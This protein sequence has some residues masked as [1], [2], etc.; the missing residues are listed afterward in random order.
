MHRLA[1]DRLLALLGDGCPAGEVVAAIE[2]DVSLLAGV[3]RLANRRQFDRGTVDSVPAALKAVRPESL[4]ALARAATT[5]DVFAFTESPAGIPQAVRQHASAVQGAA[6]G[7]AATIAFPGLDRIA[8][9]AGLHDI[10]RMVLVEAFGERACGR[11][12]V[13]MTPMA[14]LRAERERLGTDH[15]EVSAELLKF[16]G[17]PERVVGAVARHHDPAA[18]EEAVIVGL[19]DTLVHF[20]EGGPIDIETAV[21]QGAALG[22]D[23]DTL[24]RLAFDLPTG[25]V[26]RGASFEA[27]PLSDR[28]LTVLKH[29]SEGKVYKQIALEMNLTPSTVRSHLHRIY[30][31]IGAADRTQAV[32]LAKERGWLE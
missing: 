23:R 6:H 13:G 1:R 17:L 32:L 31:R 20:R 10:G 14:A 7:I 19:A 24:A 27:N 2:G 30:R 18:H 22:I 5:Y 16:W 26:R 9:I 12:T 3:M 25:P 28:E 11:G 15:A 8:V 29:L 21:A 4:Q